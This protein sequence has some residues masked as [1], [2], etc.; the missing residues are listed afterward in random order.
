NIGNKKELFC[1]ILNCKRNSGT[2][3][4]RKENLAEH[5]RRVHR[6]PSASTDAES[7]S[8]RR[9]SADP[10]EAETPVEEPEDESDGI[11]RSPLEKRKRIEEVETDPNA[12]EE[13][14]RETV[15]RLKRITEEQAER[16]KRL[17]EYA[18]ASQQQ[19]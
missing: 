3:F 19:R 15:K 14:L 2:G 6:Q 17:E 13:N 9:D 16:I 5:M 1:T 4:T 8:A 12:S 11:D 18:L 10:D 7:P